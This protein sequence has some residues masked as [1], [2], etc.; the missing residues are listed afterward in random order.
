M[1]TFTGGKTVTTNVTPTEGEPQGN[2][3]PGSATPAADTSGTPVTQAQLDALSAGI[4][5]QFD[6]LGKRLKQSTKDTV[7]HQT[8][9]VEQRIIERLAP[10]LGEGIL[11]SARREAAVDVL[12]EQPSLR[13]SESGTPEAT[14]AASANAPDVLG[15]AVGSIVRKHGLTGKEP[16]LSAYLAEN[17]GAD[18]LDILNGLNKIGGEIA[19]RRG[20][21][22]STL[23]PQVSGTPPATTLVNNY[24]DEVEAIR[25]SSW[26]KQTKLA[27]LRALKVAYREKGLD[28]DRIQFGSPGYNEGGKLISEREMPARRPLTD[29]Q[30]R[31][32]D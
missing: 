19:V 22:A 13:A 29:T 12:L 20:T 4:A 21:P 32:L 3:A 17:Q 1:R 5:K 11:E 25:T 14:P 31:R 24:L 28:P 18:L 27:K 9:S 30:G 8:K 23:T 2:V 6:D 26:D 7:E 15:E 16:E 10:H